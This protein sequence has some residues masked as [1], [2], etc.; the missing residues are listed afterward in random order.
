MTHMDDQV[1]KHIIAMI[2]RIARKPTEDHE[3]DPKSDTL[4]RVIRILR[5]SP[6]WSYDLMPLTPSSWWDDHR[7]T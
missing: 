7:E 1:A 6:E 5:G 4:N 2:R 3:S